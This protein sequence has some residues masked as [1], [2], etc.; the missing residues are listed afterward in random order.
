MRDNQPPP[1]RPAPGQPL[2]AQPARVAQGQPGQAP[3][4]QQVPA[5]PVPG[6]PSPPAAA[7]DLGA[8]L[9][10]STQFRNELVGLLRRPEELEENI[11]MNFRQI[12]Q[13]AGRQ[14]RKALR[15]QDM[16]PVVKCL[17]EKLHVPR[18]VFGEI[19]QMFW[20]FEVTGEGVLYEDEAIRLITCMLHQYRDALMPPPPGHV[21]LGDGIKHASVQELY[22]VVKEL[23]RG[24]QGIAYLA[25]SKLS[26]QEVV[27]KTYTKKGQQA[28]VE[29]ITQEFELLMRLK[30]PK[31]ARVFDIFQDW[32]NIHIVQEPYFGGD[33]TTAVA[34]SLDAGVKVD[35]R[36]LA[37]VMHQVCLGV[38]FLHNNGVVHSDLKEANVMVADAT[39][40]QQP[41]VIV[42]DFGLANKFCSKSRGGGTPGY[43]PPEVWDHGLWTPRGDMFSIGVMLFTMR[44]GQAPFTPPDLK[45]GLEEVAKR[46]RFDQPKMALGSPDIQQL[47]HSMLKKPLLERPT[48]A[49]AIEDPWFAMEMHVDHSCT[50]ELV[51]LVGRSERT[52]MY[53]ALLADITARQNLAQLRELNDLFLSLDANN[54]GLISA[55]ELREALGKAWSSADVEKL[56]KA[57]G[58][59]TGGEVSY[60][61]FIGELLA[62]KYPEESM[63]LQRIFTASDTDHTGYLNA[64]EVAELARGPA[65]ERFLG[66]RSPEA[67][68]QL[69]DA[70]RDG[71]VSF[72][73]F[74]R[75]VHN[76]TLKGR[77]HPGVKYRVGKA[78]QY[79]SRSHGAWIDCTVTAVDELH[80]A[81]QVSC[82]PDFWIQ[83]EDL[84][85]LLRPLADAAAAGGRH[86]SQ[87]QRGPGYRKGQEVLLWSTSFNAWLPCRVTAV[88][89]STGSVQ[90]DQKPHYWFHGKEL[91][92]RLRPMDAQG[93]GRGA[94]KA[95]V[96]RQVLSGAFLLHQQST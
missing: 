88:D 75:A 80:G 95:A 36:W 28:S 37:H 76:E 62:A 64:K 72:D 1:G 63:L 44:T 21:K 46:T 27:L 7:L 32:E 16:D 85:S 83:G 84:Q 43:M 19:H 33:L 24:G 50:E 8:A 91:S 89:E 41:Q 22:A 23:G 74:R 59:N 40:W 77:L 47:V 53:R 14:G 10:G 9:P 61:E 54:D 25:K 90:V 71:R 39:N 56:I 11:R 67:L 4:Q 26:G 69:M 35:E 86:A 73:E 31:I 13:P 81:V 42:I 29:E 51:R 45:G 52:D 3:P 30:H 20:R 92:T 2:L 38:Q 18:D 55:E 6:Q 15:P 34:K 87:P 66:G 17:S 68:M 94:V 78:A 60:D 58:V 12:A 82:K 49:Q 5:R 70:D 48:L 93:P 65:M 57:L 79:W 96:A